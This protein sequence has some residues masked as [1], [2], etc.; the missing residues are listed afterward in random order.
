MVPEPQISDTGPEAAPAQ[1]SV[2]T[3]ELSPKSVLSVPEPEPEPEPTQAPATV[4]IESSDVVQESVEDVPGCSIIG[5]VESRSD[6]EQISVRLRALGLKPEIQ[7]ERRNEQAGFWVLIPPQQTRQDAI[8]IAK[9]LE[10]SG[11]NDLWRFTSGDLAHAI[12][13]GLFRDEERAEVRRSEIKALGFESI[14]QPRYRESTRY[15][16]SFQATGNNPIKEIDWQG[17]LQ[18]YPQLVAEQIDCP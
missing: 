15:W 3:S 11:V 7:S 4:Q 17:L 18:D 9:R 8:K 16:L 2:E 14:I 12:S 10:R 5:Y 6:A 1:S 13:L